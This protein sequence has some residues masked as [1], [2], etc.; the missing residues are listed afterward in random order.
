MIA[1][2][3]IRLLVTKLHLIKSFDLVLILSRSIFNMLMDHDESIR[4]SMSSLITSL[5]YKEAGE[6]TNGP[7]VAIYSQQLYLRYLICFKLVPFM[8]SWTLDKF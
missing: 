7:V 4:I 3:I 5:Y 2:E 8:L 6:H 1:M